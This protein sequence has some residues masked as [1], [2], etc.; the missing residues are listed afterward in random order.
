L[1]GF[2]FVHAAGLWPRRDIPGFGV[3]FA[4]A[5]DA[6]DVPAAAWK[7]RDLSVRDSGLIVKH[8]ARVRRLGLFEVARPVPSGHMICPLPVQVFDVSNQG[9]IVLSEVRATLESGTPETLIARMAEMDKDGCVCLP[10]LADLI[11][12]LVAV[13]QCG[14]P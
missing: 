7:F 3:A 9:V 8:S 6:F 13:C 4:S 1:P 2:A 5:V 10:Q 14:E 11:H 12:V